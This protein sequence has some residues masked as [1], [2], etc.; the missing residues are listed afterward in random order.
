MERSD[1]SSPFAVELAQDPGA[2]NFDGNP[3]WAPDA[4]P[5]CPDNVNLTVLADN[6]VLIGMDCEDTGPDY[7]RT[8]V[9]EFPSSDPANGTLGPFQIGNPSTVEYTP[10]AGFRGTD[11]FEF[12]SFDGFG[13]GTDTGRVT[14]TVVAPGQD[15][16]GGGGPVPTCAGKRATIIGTPG[17]DV[18]FGIRRNDVIVGLGGRDE[19]RGGAAADT[20][21]GGGGNDVIRGLGGADRLYGN[22]GRD[23][24]SGGARNDRINGGTSHDR[25][26]GASGRD[27][28][29][30]ASGNDRLSGGSAA[31]RLSGGSGR[32]RLN[33]G[34]AR[35]RCAG[36]RGRDRAR[37]CERRSSIP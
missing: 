19:I 37:S 10:N 24:I 32:D 28:I 30:G 2:N 3:D 1:D 27:R 33:G 29:T 25:L 5:E 6:P 36:G 12:R 22:S 21:C 35:D 17:N 16:P 20:I 4:R 23:R 18:I 7:E 34:S 14:I 9:N 13:F 26:S 8:N 15:V 11:S 31:D